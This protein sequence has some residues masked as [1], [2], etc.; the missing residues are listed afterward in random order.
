LPSPATLWFDGAYQLQP[1]REQRGEGAA[2]P[3]IVQIVPEFG[4]GC[5]KTA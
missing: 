2:C 4:V 5:V 1:P 3:R